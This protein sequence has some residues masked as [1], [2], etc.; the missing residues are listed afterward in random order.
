MAAKPGTRAHGLRL[1]GT[2]Q[3]A[4]MAEAVH[5]HG[6]QMALALVKWRWS[7]GQ[8]AVMAEWWLGMMKWSNGAGQVTEAA[9]EAVACRL[10]SNVTV[11]R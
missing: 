7:N 11:K 5:R 10:H 2:G 1:S 6:G 3:T 4:D 8:T 9:V